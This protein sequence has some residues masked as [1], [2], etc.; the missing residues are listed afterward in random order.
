MCERRPTDLLDAKART[1]K[2]ES[3]L[4]ISLYRYP[5]RTKKDARQAIKYIEMCTKI[6]LF[7]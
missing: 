4:I 3:D 2:K 5:T 6:N 1:P 7:Y